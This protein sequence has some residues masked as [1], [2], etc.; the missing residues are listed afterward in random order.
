MHRQTK[1]GENR[2]S[3]R[4]LHFPV[5]HE[6]GVKGWSFTSAVNFLFLLYYVHILAAFEIYL[7]DF[8]LNTKHNFA[9][10]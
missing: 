10:K 5:E 8:C 7:F 9:L 4:S 2:L 6:T 1:S 3:A